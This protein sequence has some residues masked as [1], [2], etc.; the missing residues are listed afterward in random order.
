MMTGASCDSVIFTVGV[1]TYRLFL[2]HEY[3]ERSCSKLSEETN[4]EDKAKPMFSARR[5]FVSAP[6]FFCIHGSY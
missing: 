6:T 1:G 4:Q 3:E 5:S 2:Q